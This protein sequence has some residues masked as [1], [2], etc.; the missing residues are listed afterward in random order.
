MYITWEQLVAEF[1]KQ[2]MAGRRGSASAIL[3]FTVLRW[4]Q[5]QWPHRMQILS[6][7]AWAKRKCAATSALVMACTE[8]TM[9]EDRGNTSAWKNHMPSAPFSSIRRIRILYMPVAWEK[10][11]VPIPNGDFT[12][13]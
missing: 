10:F 7:P 12:E 8:A 13:A 4:E 11:L 6:M 9:R 2:P 5:W 3:L 1:G